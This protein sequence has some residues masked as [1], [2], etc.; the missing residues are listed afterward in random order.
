MKWFFVL[1]LA[2]AT[3]TLYAQQRY[4]R[5]D[6]QQ[7]EIPDREFL[8]ATLPLI[9]ARFKAEGL[10]TQQI[11][12]TL[13]SDREK[14]LGCPPPGQCE[15][16]T[17]EMVTNYTRSHTFSLLS[18][19]ATSHNVTSSVTFETEHKGA[20]VRFQPIGL[21]DKSVRNTEATDITRR[22]LTD[23]L[24]RNR[25]AQLDFDPSQ[26][27][28]CKSPTVCSQDLPIGIYY[29]W[30]ERQGRITSNPYSFF[31][32]INKQEKLVLVEWF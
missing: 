29:V 28:T 27:E 24:M 19:E 4:A 2:C 26:A 16:L 10:N 3:V 17:E 20:T 8:S 14:T 5:Q 31:R 22:H 6:F 23:Q 30:T 25:S 9:F 15:Q 1:G 7:Q 18:A 12:D 21:R 13:N 11:A 32:L